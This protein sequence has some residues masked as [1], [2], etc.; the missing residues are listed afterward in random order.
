MKYSLELA[1][2]T[3]RITPAAWCGLTL[4]AVLT[5]GVLQSIPSA[6][7]DEVAPV[8]EA[9]NAPALRP[10]IQQDK[11]FVQAL[12]SPEAKPAD[13]NHIIDA[14]VTQAL[15][16]KAS[17]WISVTVLKNQTL[18][19]IF[20]LVGLGDSD[21]RAVVASSPE[22]KRLT[23]LKAGDV[24][25][26]KRD[27]YGLLELSMKLDA[28]RTL[29]ISRNDLDSY[30]G[31][32][33]T[34]E[35]LRKSTEVAVEIRNS[36]YYD[37]AK[38]GLSSRTVNEFI[39]LFD[40]DIDYAQDLQPGDSFALVYEQIFTKDGKKLRDGEILAA[41]FRVG[42]ERYQAVRFTQKDGTTAYYTPEG[43]SLKKAFIRTPLDQARITSAYNPKR[44]HPIFHTIKA[45]KGVDYGAPAGTPIKSTGD[46][47]I[48]FQGVKGGYGNVTIVKHWGQYE[49]LYAHM[50][51]FQKGLKVGSKVRMGQV[52]GAVGSSGWATAAHLHYEFHINGAHVNP[53]TVELPRAFPI[54]DRK[55]LAL[56]KKQSAHLMTRIS[57]ALNQFVLA[58]K[59]R[60]G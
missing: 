30:E 29:E 19:Q 55:Q 3:R 31:V 52:I 49:T 37:G 5:W 13:Y 41:E 18:S 42:K 43:R 22:A 10:T 51:K 14:A 26:I 44:V 4:S 17:D 8:V 38:A 35:V 50:S 15:V 47:E 12:T 45:H 58:K 53:V 9:T 36:L 54:E 2:K 34:A 57:T 1:G 56:F 11:P 48:V 59:D 24:L 27:G 60:A 23:K 33:E 25:R 46:G 39:K 20:E 6:S 40:Y 16:P 7:A 21:W 32:I 28:L